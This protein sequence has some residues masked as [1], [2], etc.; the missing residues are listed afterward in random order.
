M[1]N[2]ED[3][4]EL[5]LLCRICPPIRGLLLAM[6][7]G[8]FFFIFLCLC[9]APNNAFAQE[10]PWVFLPLTPLFEP[11]IGNPQEPHTSLIAYGNQSRFEGTVGTTMEIVRCQPPGQTQ[12]G[13]GFFGA[14]FILLDENGA[15]FPMRA[16]DWCAGIYASESYGVFENRL[17]FQHQSSHLGDS[18][19]GQREI[20]IYNGENFNI[21]TSLRPLDGLRFYAGAGCWI[22]FF[23]SDNTFFASL[24]TE[25]YSPFFG[26]AGTSLRGYSTVDLNWKTPAGGTLDK[27]LQLGLQWKFKKQETRS[28][29]AALVYYN[30]HSEF[31]QFHADP[32][33][34]WGFGLF[35]DP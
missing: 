31:G 15:S 13:M 26:V 2:G 32:D 12:W 27:T 4:S 18:L 10:N 21:T 20:L 11:L 19:E 16:G 28:I 9:V 34:H 33:E 5:E 23:P 30:G 24:G 14:G 1:W 25:I 8:S 17:E 29:R 7:T 22:D 3:F 6:I 35:F